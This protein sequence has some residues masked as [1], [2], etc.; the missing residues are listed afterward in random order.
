M[1]VYSK[2]LLL[3]HEKLLSIVS[4]AYRLEEFVLMAPSV[5]GSRPTQCKE[6]TEI[7]IYYTKD[8]FVIVQ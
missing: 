4:C 6:I 5:S 2:H 7:N 1:V 8:D 3:C